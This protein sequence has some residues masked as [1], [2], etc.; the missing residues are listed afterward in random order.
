MDVEKIIRETVHYEYYAND[1]NCAITTLL[2][3]GKIFGFEPDE[4]LIAAAAGLHGA[5]GYR[6][7][8]GLVEGG[9]MSIGIVGKMR[10]LSGERIVR[11][12]YEYAEAF[13]REFGALR[14]R[15]LRPNGFRE[16]DPPHLCEDISVRATLFCYNYIKDM[17]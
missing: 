11:L 7:Q 12:C 5:G 16:D 9:L 17:H 15:E 4:Q 3:L 1:T 10:K 8:C 13:E 6:A 14:C 2:C